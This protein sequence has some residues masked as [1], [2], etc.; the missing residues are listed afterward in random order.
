MNK[1][2]E[3]N[4]DYDKYLEIYS[5]NEKITTYHKIILKENENI[6]LVS[7]ETIEG[8][9]IRLVAESLIPIEYLSIKRAESYLDIG[10]GGGLPS[11]PIILTQDIQKAVLIERTQKKAAA[12]KRILNA[13]DLNSKAA[14]FN[15][16]LEDID[17]K[18]RF[19][20]ITLRLVKL[21]DKLLSYILKNLKENG[22][23][24]YYSDYNTKEINNSCS[25]VTYSYATSLKSPNKYFTVIRK[26]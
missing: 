13:L 16:T 20:L 18:T 23:L 17:M 6:N 19:D 9:F 8:G 10:S 25:C 7:R 26:I 22:I 5:S 21:T 14:V 4:I 2:T 1:I 24:I 3:L 12:L 15:Q 11:I